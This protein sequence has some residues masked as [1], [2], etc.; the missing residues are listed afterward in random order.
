MDRFWIGGVE[1]AF[2]HQDDEVLLR[3]ED[4]HAAERVLAHAGARVQALTALRPRL[5]RATLADRDAAMQRL[6]AQGTRVHHV[7]RL[8]AAPEVEL[9]IGDRLFLGGPDPQRLQQWLERYHLRV[10]RPVGACRVLAEVT[11]ATG[12][13]ALRLVAHLQQEYHGEGI[14]AEPDLYRVLEPAQ[15]FLPADPEFPRQWHLHAPADGE[16][17][18]A[19]ADIGAP[20]AWALTRGNRDVVI[21]IADDGIDLDHPDFAGPGKI[22]GALDVVP[23]EGGRL[24]YRP[25]PRPRGAD[26]HGTPCAGVALAEINGTG[27]VGVA[28]GCALLAVRFPLTALSDSQFAALFERISLEADVL[29]CSWGVGPTLAPLSQVLRDTIARLT[30]SGGRR[31]RGL[32]ICVAAGNHN[33]PLKDHANTRSYRYHD[34]VRWRQYSGPIDRWIATHPDVIV[35]SGCTSLKKRAAY[36]S[37]GKEVTLCAPTDNWDDQQRVPVRGRG[38]VTTD[39]ERFGTGFGPGPYT[40]R[41][42]GTSSATPTVAGVAGLMLSADPTLTAVEVKELLIATADRDLDLDSE[43][44]VPVRGDFIDGHSPWFG[45][46]KVRADRAVAATLAR[47]PSSSLT[48]VGPRTQKP[49]PQRPQALAVAVSNGQSGI[50]KQVRIGVRLKHP[51]PRDVAVVLE[52]PDGRQVVLF[53]PGTRVGV[54][55]EVYGAHEVPALRALLGAEAAGRFRLLLSDRQAGGRGRLLHWQVDLVLQTPAPVPN[56]SPNAVSARRTAHS[57]SGKRR[58]AAQ[59]RR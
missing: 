11:D 19:G 4:A 39:N 8:R 20:A 13:N 10:L 21:C 41:F 59:R 15:P 40:D 36:S 17:L 25:D 22:R 37:W 2:E 38:I 7:Y 23:G 57:R 6:R 18:R 44:E 47:A 49:I 43:T 9:L 12:R 35:V 14:Y 45:A 29:S 58:A 48:L 55:P 33:A 42:G 27:T 53:D 34:G 51:R 52:V 30:R 26:Y 5:V 3:V 56:S 54:P 24:Y 50:V 1:L 16:D 28:P 31:G 46:G 32:A